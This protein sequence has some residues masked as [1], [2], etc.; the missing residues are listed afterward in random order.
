MSAQ[1][2]SA[3]LLREKIARWVQDHLAGRNADIVTAVDQLLLL[4]RETGELR[5][6]PAGDRELRFEFPDQEPLEIRLEIARSRLRTVCA[7]LAFLCHES[8]QE[9]EPYGGEGTIERAVPC[10]SADE[11]ANHGRRTWK[12]RWKNTTAA[13][14][15]TIQAQ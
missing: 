15:F 14:E 8:G 1:A 4:A 13:Q 2:P 6:V 5:C 12:V 3:N 11:T 10:G 7:R 9:F